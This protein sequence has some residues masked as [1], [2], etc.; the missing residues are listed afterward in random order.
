VEF[1]AQRERRILVGTVYG[2]DRDDFVDQFAN[3]EKLL[4]VQVKPFEQSLASALVDRSGFPGF[5]FFDPTEHSDEDR[6][7]IARSVL[8]NVG[9]DVHVFSGQ[10]ENPEFDF[11]VKGT[12]AGMF[13]KKRRDRF[14]GVFYDSPNEPR[15]F[16]EFRKQLV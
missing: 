10:K 15:T 3:S 2:I 16:S 9:G 8:P 4:D 12:S 11:V 14:S 13:S 5:R 1:P 7:D 6:T